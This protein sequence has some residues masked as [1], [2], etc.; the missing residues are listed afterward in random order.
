MENFKVPWHAQNWPSMAIFNSFWQISQKWL[1][2]T[3]FELRSSHELCWGHSSVSR[4]TQ[5]GTNT[6]DLSIFTLVSILPISACVF[7]TIKGHH[8]V[9]PIYTFFV[10]KNF[11]TEIYSNVWI[12][13][14]GNMDWLHLACKLESTR[15]P[16]C[17]LESTMRRCSC[18]LKS[19]Q[20]QLALI[21]CSRP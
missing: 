8:C 2:T 15:C 18:Q 17:K 21:R 3:S 13:Y 10:S 12:H 11:N 19:K 9:H 7:I 6:Y 4:K 5:L 20:M 14:F 16:G 1:F